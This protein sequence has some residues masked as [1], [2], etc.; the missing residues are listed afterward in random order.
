MS[1]ADVTVL[2]GL[3]GLEPL[4]VLA[5]RCL[6]RLCY[7]FAPGPRLN[8][9][10]RAFIEGLALRWPFGSVLRQWLRGFACMARTEVLFLA[11][12]A[13]SSVGTANAIAADWDNLGG[14]DTDLHLVVPVEP[15]QSI[16]MDTNAA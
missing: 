14:G 2:A 15:S 11:M 12:V 10:H 8:E 3:F 5:R 6:G 13:P 4:R 9:D 1:G 7:R 16:G